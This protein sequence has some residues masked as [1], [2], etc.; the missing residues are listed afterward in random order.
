MEKFDVGLALRRIRIEQN[1]SQ[2]ALAKKAGIGQDYI[3]HIENRK[4]V[5][6]LKML[7]QILMAMDIDISHFFTVAEAEMM[8]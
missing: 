2:N 8:I 1:L 3:S 7:T 4:K 6:S 5:P